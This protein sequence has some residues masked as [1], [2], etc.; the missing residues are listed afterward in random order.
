MPAVH[1]QHCKTE[2]E[3][4]GEA[5]AAAVLLVAGYVKLSVCERGCLISLTSG[6][7]V[8]AQAAPLSDLS[9]GTHTVQSGE[10]GVCVQSMGA[11]QHKRPLGG[12][13]RMRISLG[14]AGLLH[15]RGAKQTAASQKR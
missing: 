15:P 5:H 3:S 9:S 14:W 12:D 7:V 10:V 8:P 4:R 2:R 6:S 1:S 11:K 13:S